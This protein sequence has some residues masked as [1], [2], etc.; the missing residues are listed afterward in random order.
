MSNKRGID[1]SYCQGQP[2]FAKL[3]KS[4]DFVI[5]QAGYGRY[6]S[7]KDTTFERNYSQCKK[8]GIPCGVYWFSYA[9]SAAE[10]KLE[11]A[12]C[13]EVIRGKQFEY[14]IY[15][16]VE[17]KSLINRTA[18]SAMCEAFCGALEKAGYFAGIYMSRSPAQ[19]MLTS[20]AA[21]KYALWLAEYG[22]KLNWSGKVGMWQNSST[23]KVSGVSG[24]VDTDICY[25]DYPEIIKE[26]G[27]NG[28]AK[29]NASKVL[30]STGMKRGDK[31]LGVLAYK[32]LLIIAKAKGYIST[33][34]KN[35]SGFGAGTEKAT[36]ELLKR[37]GFMENGIAGDELVRRLGAEILKNL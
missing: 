29:P 35:D 11:A 1:I 7:Q 27:K 17:G 8:Y 12:A 13:L 20:E 21:N 14:P 18:V 30:D 10:A 16:D 32:Q 9:K 19:T 23:G 4:V 31:S 34:V 28:Y 24:S 36:N 15:F 26:T 22:S 25:V 2:D 33:A 3:A 37:F 6:S 5:M